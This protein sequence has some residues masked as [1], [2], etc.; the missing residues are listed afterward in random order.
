MTPPLVHV[1]VINWNGMEHVEECFSS[2]L[3]TTYSN[4]RF[5]L[6]DNASTDGSPE[7]VQEHFGHDSRVEFLRLPENRG[8]SG[9][10]NAGI[11]RAL[12]AGADYVLLLNNDTWVAPSA[13]EMLVRAGEAYPGTGAFAPKMLLYDNPRLI[14]SMGIECSI[15]GVGW[16][17]G[18][19]QPDGPKWDVPRQVLGVC[20]GAAFFRTSILRKTGL[21]PTDF[22]IYLDD[23]D[24]CLRIWD[25]GS[26]VWTCPGAVVRHKFS[27]TM[28]KGKRARRKYYLNTRNRMR[29]MLRHFPRRRAAAILA[30]FAHGEAKALG[31][32][33]LDRQLWKILAHL[34]AWISSLLY[35]PAARRMRRIWRDKGMGNCRFWPLVRTDCL[36]PQNI[37]MP[38]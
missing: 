1:L 19:G 29:L 20:G 16:D 9:G 26:E 7:F 6:V 11:E 18:L 35:I 31:R 13:V 27:A 15:I 25:L 4:V 38:K 5:V 30:A 12:E 37:R 21:L 22:E 24:L 2:L 32:A 10:N 8:W 3:A 36:F 34:R 14:N 28:G 33:M 23:L 17:L